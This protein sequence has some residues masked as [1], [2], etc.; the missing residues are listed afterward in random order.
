MGENL[1]VFDFEVGVDSYE[2][3]A[4]EM[5][6][7]L[8]LK[9][10]DVPQLAKTI[11]DYVR[12]HSRSQNTGA[13]AL[14]VVAAAP[15]DAPSS[16]TVV[17]P[18]PSTPP[19]AAQS[20]AQHTAP[21]EQSP[22]PQPDSA[23]S[24]EEQQRPD[25]A[26]PAAKTDVAQSPNVEATSEAPPSATVDKKLRAVLSSESLASDHT[27]DDEDFGKRDD[28]AQKE[29]LRAQHVF[30]FR[31]KKL[32]D[33]QSNYQQEGEKLTQAYE[34]EIRE[35]TDKMAKLVQERDEQLAALAQEIQARRIEY[36]AK[37][38]EEKYHREAQRRLQNQQLQQRQLEQQQR[39]LQQYWLLNT[40]MLHHPQQF[41]QMQPNFSAMPTPSMQDWELL[42]SALAP[43][44]RTPYPMQ[45]LQQQQPQQT[46]H[47]MQPN[48]SSGGD[49][50]SANHS[51]HP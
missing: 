4:S 9:D 21:I 26:G 19:P 40:S 43:E 46:T 48:S 2:T 8:H 17:P 24:R 1:V 10:L 42:N 15:A 38:R 12:S 44:D 16:S 18:S 27:G 22:A 5:Q 23:R 28:D 45:F 39:M 41:A 37:C 29:L 33:S 47:H 3:V 6:E 36:L 11:E 14:A 25:A 51:P 49:Q 31:R 50:Y 34:K 32:E 30:N 7:Q 20:D 13:Q 35:I